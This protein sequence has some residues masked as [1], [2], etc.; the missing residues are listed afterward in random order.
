VIHPFLVDDIVGGFV[1]N[2]MQVLA[3]MRASYSLCI[4]D[5]QFGS[6]SASFVPVFVLQ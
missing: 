5:F 1:W 6:K 2:K 4:A 3:A